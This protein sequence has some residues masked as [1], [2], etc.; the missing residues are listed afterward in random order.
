VGSLYTSANFVKMG[1]CTR[2]GEYRA[3]TGIWR[4]L[5]FVSARTIKGRSSPPPT[6]CSTRRFGAV[7]SFC[8]NSRMR[9][10][11]AARIMRDALA[12]FHIFFSGQTHVGRGRPQSRRN[13]GRRQ[14]RQHR[15]CRSRRVM[16]RLVHTSLGLWYLIAHVLHCS[17]PPPAHSFI[18]GPAV[19]NTHT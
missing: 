1:H 19:I 4:L 16:G 17:P 15:R 12:T 2:R 8:R 18:I 10:S 9:S 6:L 11:Q 14:R 13:H 3:Q 7:P 5:G